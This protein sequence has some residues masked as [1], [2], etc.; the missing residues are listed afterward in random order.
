MY[1]VRTRSVTGRLRFSRS[2]TASSASRLIAPSR[3]D[4]KASAAASRLARSTGIR[5]PDHVCQIGSIARCQGRHF[6]RS[7]DDSGR[8]PRLLPIPGTRSR[9]VGPDSFHDRVGSWPAHPAERTRGQNGADRYGRRLKPGDKSVHDRIRICRTCTARRREEVRHRLTWPTCGPRSRKVGPDS[10]HDRV[11]WWA[12]HRARVQYFFGLHPVVLIHSPHVASF[13]RAPPAA[14]RGD[15]GPLPPGPQP[16]STLA[17]ALVLV[18][19]RSSTGSFRRPGLCRT[20]TP[21]PRSCPG[22]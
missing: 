22:C 11:G 4:A 15:T 2:N 21:R 6:T 5:H 3:N 9:K 8:L 16:S 10:F 1:V 7:R 18:L 17:L 12:G 19:G 14:A 20:S 13:R